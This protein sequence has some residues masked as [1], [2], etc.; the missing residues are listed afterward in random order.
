[1]SEHEQNNPVDDVLTGHAFKPLANVLRDRANVIARRWEELVRQTLPRADALTLA[2]VRNQIPQTLSLLADTLESN[3]PD[4]IRNLDGHSGI[5]GGDRFTQGYNIEELLVEY[6]LLRRVVIEEIESH[7]GRR[8][9][10]EEDVALSMGVDTVLHRGVTAFFRNMQAELS[11]ASDAESKFLAYLSHDLR[12]QLNHVMLVLELI[13]M[14][15]HDN[16]EVAGD[17]KEIGT[18]RRA[19]HETIEGMERLIKASRLRSGRAEL[20]LETVNLEELVE[21]LA[22]PFV[23]D[24]AVK[25]IEFVTRVPPGASSVSD[26]RLLMVILHNLL[27]N[28][29]KYSDRGTIRLEVTEVENGWQISVA[30]EGKGISE[31]NKQRIFEEFVRGQTH[32][33]PGAGLGLAIVSRAIKLLEA[34]I[35][36][37]S[38]PGKGSIFTV[39]C[40]RAASSRP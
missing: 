27:T 35:T 9:T 20:K 40:L 7:L 1:M 6:R 3:K 14:K 36:V 5:H 15:L 18:V 23:R 4:E 2:E 25:G 34:E 16:P 12:N 11:A 39:T 21:A 37:Q 33:K 38:E 26:R 32:G 22:L 31:E 17:L 30:D 28:A 29:I 10:R 13:G 19:I 24:A 8:T